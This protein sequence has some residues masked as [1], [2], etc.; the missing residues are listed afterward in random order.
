MTT[1]A[2]RSLLGGSEIYGGFMYE[3]VEF[4]NNGEWRKRIIFAN[5]SEYSQYI[6]VSDAVIVI[7]AREQKN[8][9]RIVI[10]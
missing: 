1:Q 5:Q 8:Y 10:I 3:R 6:N 9:Y 7:E 4:F 2:A